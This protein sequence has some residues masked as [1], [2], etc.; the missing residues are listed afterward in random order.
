[1]TDPSRETGRLTQTVHELKCWPPYF[2]LLL[3][4][5]KPFELRR[6]DRDFHVG[7]T[8]FLREWNPQTKEYT[9]REC[10]RVIT[11]AL[12]VDL[13]RSSFTTADGDTSHEH[14][15]LG[16]ADPRLDAARATAHALEGQLEKARLDAREWREAYHSLAKE[17][18]RG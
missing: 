15:I 7:D 14:M 16:L 6:A 4:G 1:M 3:S 9:G 10:H 18:R 5:D 8:L 12:A 2:E 17:A 11:C 13:W